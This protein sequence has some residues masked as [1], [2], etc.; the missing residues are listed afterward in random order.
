MEMILYLSILS[1]I[2]LTLSSFLFLTYTSRVKATVIAEVEQQGNQT[3][4]LLT[5]NI[6]NASQITTPAAGNSA[7]SLTLVEYDGLV[8]PTV[9]NQSGN[10]MQ[11][12][13]GAS[14]AVNI[15][16]NRVVVSGLTFQNLSRSQTPGVIKISYTLTHVNPENRGEYNY[17][18]TFTSTAS[19][20]WP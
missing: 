5:K 3:M 14:S 7:A 17:S 19:L 8:T 15:T 20:R 2:V 4:S 9:I 1:I 16:S 18:K 10:T 13:E 12:K 11:I 6:R